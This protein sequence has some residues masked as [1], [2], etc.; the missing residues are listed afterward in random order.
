MKVAGGATITTSCA[1]R[2]NSTSNKGASNVAGTGCLKASSVS[3]VGNAKGACVNP[4]AGYRRRPDGRSLG[5]SE[6]TH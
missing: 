6:S 4:A 3:V 5:G 2:V 1:I